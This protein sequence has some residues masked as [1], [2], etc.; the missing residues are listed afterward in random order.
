MIKVAFINSHGAV[1]GGSER[2]LEAYLRR[3]PSGIC[4]YVV[5]FEDGSYADHLRA[6]NIPVYVVAASSRLMSVTR[7]HIHAADAVDGI[8]HAFRLVK[9][10]RLCGI[11]VV[12][13]NTMKAHIVGSLAARLCGI[14]AV[15][16][17]HDLPEGRALKLLRAMS[18]VCARERI[19]CSRAV[20]KRFGLGH[21]TALA[22]AIELNTYADTPSK[23]E[24]RMRLGLPQDKLV[25][26]IIGRVAPW[27]GQDRFIRAAARVCDRTNAVHFSIVGSPTF[28]QDKE[29]A[30]EL[31]ELAS[32][33]GISQD[34]SFI[35]WLE[36][37]KIA[38]AA[39][40]LVCNASAAEPFGRTSAEAAAC[41]VPALCFDDGGAGEAVLPAVTGTLVPAGDVEAFAAAMA[42]YAADPPALHRAGE[43]ARVY[44]QRQDADT[45]AESFYE[46]VRRACKVPSLKTAAGT[47]VPSNAFQ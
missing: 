5:V 12:V 21:T 38:Y 35:P 17:W 43:A 47:T 36:D 14:P 45:L 2:S 42:A 44:V 15:T 1:P 24:A 8:R 37:P 27:K 29:F 28:P 34:V 6:L 40:D 23:M 26:S 4:P 33:L 13:T 19:A 18:A 11:D 39:S 46:I 22:P 20:L 32:H 25:F 31:P 30:A 7:E 9:L 3:A 10:F 41:G 16:W